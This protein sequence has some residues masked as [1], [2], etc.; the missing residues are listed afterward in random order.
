MSEAYRLGRI[1]IASDIYEQNL[2]D[3][4]TNML[5]Q[6]QVRANLVVP[7]IKNSQLWGLFCIHQCSGPRQWQAVETAFVQR[8]AAQLGLA[9]QQ[10]DSLDQVQ[11]KTQQLEA[12]VEK[13]QLI[14]KITERLRVTSNLTDTLR[15]AVKDVRR[16]MQADRVGS[17]SST[18]PKTTAWA[19]L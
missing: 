12:S 18:R 9:M 17:F 3:C 13:E 19:N 15:T 6:F 8:V 10:A 16:L 7:L 14:T 1:W 5:S 11:E 4:H 2:P